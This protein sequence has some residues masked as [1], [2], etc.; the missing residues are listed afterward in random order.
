MG[1]LKSAGFKA[2]GL[3]CVF[4]GPDDT[5]GSQRCQARD[6]AQASPRGDNTH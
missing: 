6:E 2:L 1:A 4:K 3:L 5:K